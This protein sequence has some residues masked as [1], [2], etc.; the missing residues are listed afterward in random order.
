MQAPHFL[1]NI[2]HPNYKVNLMKPEHTGAA[3]EYL[4]QKNPDL[5]A[6]FCHFQADDLSLP[7][8]F[9][10]ESCFDPKATVWWKCVR[11][12]SLV[13]LAICYLGMKLCT[14]PASSASIE[15]IFSQFRLI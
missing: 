2:L 14:M 15:R 4:P 12:L 9:F 8:S 5:T 7:E 1:A 10:H 3:Q 6:D 11:K 13:N